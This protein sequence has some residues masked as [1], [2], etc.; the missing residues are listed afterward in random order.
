[1]EPEDVRSRLKK[2]NDG[3]EQG[4]REEED[5][6]E[7]SEDKS[8][9][10]E[11]TLD[12]SFVEENRIDE[13]EINRN[14]DHERDDKNVNE[15]HK[16]QNR[17]RNIGRPKETTKAVMEVQR[18]GERLEREKLLREEGVRRSER[19]KNRQSVMLVKE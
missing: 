6:E 9:E 7:E 11:D 14:K 15:I 5:E 18:N 10:Y 3:E 16:Q 17:L 19:I 2:L 12:E 13:R 8:G 1:L 4:D